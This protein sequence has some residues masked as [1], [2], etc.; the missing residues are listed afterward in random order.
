[1]PTQRGR[2][3]DS[4]STA[5]SAG[6]GIG[7]ITP[8]PPEQIRTAQLVVASHVDDPAELREMLQALGICNREGKISQVRGKRPIGTWRQTHV[9]LP[10]REPNGRPSRAAARRRKVAS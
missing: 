10:D 4:L 1:M 3:P 8:R 9:K 5:A 2:I 7:Q 6:T